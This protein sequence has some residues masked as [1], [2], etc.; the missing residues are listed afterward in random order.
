MSHRA[1]PGRE[2]DFSIAGLYV[3]RYCVSTGGPDC[4]GSIQGSG[5]GG[6]FKFFG[7]E[8]K[9]RTKKTAPG[10]GGLDEIYIEPVYNGAPY[11]EGSSPHFLGVDFSTE[12]CPSGRRGAPGKGVTHLCWVRGF[13]S[14]P[15]RLGLPGIGG[16][17]AVPC[18][19][20]GSACKPL[21]RTEAGTRG[22]VTS[23]ILLQAVPKVR[24]HAI[25]C[26]YTPSGPG[27]SSGH[28]L[29]YVPWAPRTGAGWSR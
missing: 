20:G 12:R 21:S 15:L 16:A 19:P 25:G 11:T 5:V 22:D 7:P 28:W 4:F 9:K 17:L 3:Q 1:Q 26:Q 10:G 8:K 2:K 27:G 18:D 23:W 6:G 24:S 14:L 13:E 29:P